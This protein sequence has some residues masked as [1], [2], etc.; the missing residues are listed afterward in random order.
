MECSISFLEM[1]IWIMN[2]VWIYI[3][4]LIE[5][6]LNMRWGSGAQSLRYLGETH[7]HPDLCVPFHLALACNVSRV[8]S[9]SSRSCNNLPWPM[10]KPQWKQKTRIQLRRRCPRLYPE[11]TSSTHPHSNRLERGRVAKSNCTNWVH[12]QCSWNSKESE[13]RT[14]WLRQ[15]PAHPGLRDA[16]KAFDLP[17][18]NIPL[19]R[20]N[21]RGWEMFP[22]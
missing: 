11:Q 15:I 16:R 22:P 20:R 3:W 18:C 4:R 5:L 19:G 9:K 7:L 10:C 21:L 1:D 14:Y 17:I 2:V 8:R 12:C 6:R 13:E